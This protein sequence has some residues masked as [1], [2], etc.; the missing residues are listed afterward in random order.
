VVY[1]LHNEICRNV[2]KAVEP[3]NLAV[4]SN[5]KQ[6]NMKSSRPV[7]SGGMQLI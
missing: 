2:K 5:V 1:N 3:S 7:H 6:F 4:Y